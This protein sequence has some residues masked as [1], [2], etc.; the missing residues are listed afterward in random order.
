MSAR[1]YDCLS[2]G[3]VVADHICDP[4]DHVP[5]PGELVTT[6]RMDLS[7]G[8]CAANVAVNL[9]K[10]G[11]KVGVAGTV[12][13]DVLGRFVRESLQATGV[14]CQHLRESP[15]RDTSSTLV[16]NTRGQDRRFIH[17]IGANDELTGKE[18]T[19]RLLRECKILYLGGYCLVETLTAANV[20]AVF[21]AARSAGVTTLLD[22][23]IPGPGDYWPMLEP[24]LP[25]TDFF[26]P[27]EDEGQLI[28]A[29]DDPLQQAE[30]FRHSGVKTVVVTCGHDG[31][32][33]ADDCQTLRASSYPVNFV[34]G[35]GSGDAFVAGYIYGLLSHAETK[36][37]LR[38]G[39]ALGASCVR[40]SGATTGVFTSSELEAFV[41]SQELPV[42][43]LGS[44]AN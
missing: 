9:T 14:C 11:F 6:A 23:V 30:A 17:S 10:L 36:E 40:A 41:E 19:P 1:I 25:V 5:A 37:C 8:G 24:V 32:V 31:A 15:T 27:N 43:R 2:S 16:I 22:V 29:C 33:L 7:I 26:F 4:I 20:A 42:T 3:I 39:S 38:Y 13:N 28:T 35:T 12:G 21:K 34:D 18:L 44:P